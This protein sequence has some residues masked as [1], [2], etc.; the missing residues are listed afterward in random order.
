MSAPSFWP[1]APSVVSANP[2][3]AMRAELASKISNRLKVMQLED[4][5]EEGEDD[6]W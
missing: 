3:V 2:M 1:A 6:D 4:E 5:E